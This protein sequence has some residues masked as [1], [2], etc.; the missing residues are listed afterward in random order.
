MLKKERA[1]AKESNQQSLPPPTTDYMNTSAYIQTEIRH[2]NI[3]KKD[4]HQEKKSPDGGGSSP[5]AT[6]QK[7]KAALI[8]ISPKHL[9]N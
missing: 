1:A 8:P 5:I 6:K 2:L 3:L 4:H 9:A 7:S